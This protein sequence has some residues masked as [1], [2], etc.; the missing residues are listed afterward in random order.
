[1][2]IEIQEQMA[3]P[4]L[5]NTDLAFE[6]TILAYE[7]TLMAWVRTAISLISFGF[8]LY[9]F[10]Q[11]WRKNEEP[12]Q[13]IFTPRIVG[14][15]MILFGLVALLFAEIQHLSAVKKLRR[16]YPKAQTSLTSVLGF[17][18]L[19]FGLALFLAALLRK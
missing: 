14:M 7:R 12:V 4:T 1:M 10:F 13:S 15:V 17:L 11:E 3:H 9:K 2:A 5:S 8:T 6:R 19:M 16:D 18:I